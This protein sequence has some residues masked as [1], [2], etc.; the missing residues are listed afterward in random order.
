[1]HSNQRPRSQQSDKKLNFSRR[2]ARNV[3]KVGR[4]TEFNR[5]K[6]HFSGGGG[7][8]DDMTVECCTLELDGASEI[9]VGT[10]ARAHTHTAHTDGRWMN[11]V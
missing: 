2:Q 3:E 4:T 1:M 10:H 11:E 6:Y 9:L 8:N 5:D 7:K